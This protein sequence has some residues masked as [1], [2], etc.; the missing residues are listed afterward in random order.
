MISFV[1]F[2]I[3]TNGYV[4]TPG[5]E[6]VGDV[7]SKTWIGGKGMITAIIIGLVVGAVYSWFLEKN[8]KIKMSADVLEGVTNSFAPLIPGTV[9]ILGATVIYMI[10]RY[11]FNTTLIEWIYI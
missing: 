11:G 6:K 3:T 8:I 9:I 7:L 5:G 2:L 1:V 10:F 4:I